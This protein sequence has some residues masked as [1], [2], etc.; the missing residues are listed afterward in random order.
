VVKDKDAYCYSS[1]T[2]VYEVILKCNT[3]EAAKIAIEADKTDDQYNKEDGIV[4]PSIHYY[5]LNA[6]ALGRQYR[7]G[8]KLSENDKEV[9]CTPETRYSLSDSESRQ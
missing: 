9:F 7:K 1:D 6:K 4:L 8:D 5:V 3:E 2:Y